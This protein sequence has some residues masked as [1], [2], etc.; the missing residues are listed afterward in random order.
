[1]TIES[2]AKM[3]NEMAQLLQR[4]HGREEGVLESRIPSLSTIYR[5]GRTEPSHRLYHPAFCYIASG[6]KEL[7]LADE[8]LEYG[9]NDYL[10]ASMDVPVIGK[11][12]QATAAEPYLSLKLDFTPVEL[13]EVAKEA[14]LPVRR[15]EPSPRAL[16]VEEIEPSILEAVLRYVRLLDRPGDI[17]FLA[18][19]YK[20]EILYRLLQGRY[21]LMLSQLAIEDSAGFRIRDALQRI[22]RDFARPLRVDELAEEARMSPSTFHRHFKDATAMSP[23]QFQKQLRLQEAR[24]LLIAESLDAADA[25]FRVGYE[26]SSQFSREYARMFGAPPAAD[27]KRWQESLPTSPRATS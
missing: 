20:K 15:N 14:G 21:G 22:I 17:P 7:R 24:R 11:I 3:Q 26:S 12:I 2:L 1:M 16:A 27:R 8:R 13:I 18:P 19:I 5:I 9:P 10:I 4:H 23:I 25:A 6:R